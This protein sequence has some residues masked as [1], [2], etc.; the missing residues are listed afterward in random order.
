M[1]ARACVERLLDARVGLLLER[2][3]ECASAL[4][5]ARLEHRLQPRRAA[6]SAPAPAASAR[7]ARIEHAAQ[8]VVEPDR[9]RCPDGACRDRFARG[10]IESARRDLSLMK[11]C[12][13]CRPSRERRSLSASSNGRV[14]GITASRRAR[15]CVGGVAETIGGEACERVFVS[16]RHWRQLPRRTGARR[17]R[18]AP[19]LR[20]W[21]RSHVIPSG[22]SIVRGGAGGGPP[23]PF[24]NRNSHVL[25]RRTSWYLVVVAALQR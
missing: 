17:R 14:R 11:T 3:V 18:Q 7:R 24:R 20:S 12:F 10:G 21:K 22:L 5:I 25:G 4:G 13:V 1:A 16:R 19:A 2:L 8:A 6:R 23:P 15:R 9:L